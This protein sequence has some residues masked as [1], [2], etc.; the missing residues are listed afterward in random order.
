MNKGITIQNTLA[1]LEMLSQ[2]EYDHLL[3]K[4]SAM[5]PES[6]KNESGEGIFVL[7]DAIDYINHLTLLLAKKP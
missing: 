5:I 1:S 2:L 3:N 6:R 7:N 4:L